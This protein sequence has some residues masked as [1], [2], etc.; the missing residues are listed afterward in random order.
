ML[1]V[2]RLDQVEWSKMT[3]VRRESKEGIH[4][5][6]RTYLGNFDMPI[7]IEQWYHSQQN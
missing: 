5:D 7:E 6:N 1:L 4:F 2:N 3:L